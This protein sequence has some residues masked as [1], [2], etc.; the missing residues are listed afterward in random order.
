MV[1]IPCFVTNKQFVINIAYVARDTPW[2]T[3]WNVAE[4]IHCNDV[5]MDA[6]ASQITSASIVYSAV[7]SGADQRKWS[8]SLASVREIHRWPVNSPHKGSVTR[9]MFPFDDIIMFKI[10]LGYIG[11]GYI[12]YACGKRCTKVRECFPNHL[13]HQFKV[14]VIIF[15]NWGIAVSFWVYSS[16]ENT[17]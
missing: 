9:I 1:S 10:Q 6:M 12:L 2:K 8:A 3:N 16:R 11:I 5:I 15:I 13:T 7:C 14:Q 17:H 4:T